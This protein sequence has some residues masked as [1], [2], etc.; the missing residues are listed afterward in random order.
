MNEL[1]TKLGALLKLERE[2][3]GMNLDEV[4]AKLNMTAAS[5]EHVE[6]GN[7]P[8]LPSE[9][10]FDLFSKTYAQLLGIDYVATIDAIREEIGPLP[11]LS[12]DERAANPNDEA[13]KPSGLAAAPGVEEIP[14]KARRPINRA[15]FWIGGLIVF[16][17]LVVAV[18]K[19]LFSPK[20]L[21]NIGWETKSEPADEEVGAAD[22]D[23]QVPA[24]QPPGDLDVTLQARGA[25]WTTVVTDGDTVISRELYSGEICQFSA[26]HRLRLSIGAPNLVAVTINGREVDLVDPSS[27]RISDVT[28]DHLNLDQFLGHRVAGALPAATDS[29]L[30][31][32]R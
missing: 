16:A 5:L 23:W 2:R 21:E 19:M 29:N 12:G 3:Q 27:G 7:A 22:Y 1:R 11:D 26:S 4:A 9:I 18:S 20:A 8:G 25:S 15:F 10:Y 24:Y 17:V 28:V 32:R 6:G 13:A 30:P 14:A 31:G